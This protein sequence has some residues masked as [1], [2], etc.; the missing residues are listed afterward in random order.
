MSIPHICF[1]GDKILPGCVEGGEASAPQGCHRSAPVNCGTSGMGSVPRC[2]YTCVT[3]PGSS[4]GSLMVSG[5][6]SS[7]TPITGI[8][9]SS[10]NFHHLST[11]THLS[12]ARVSSQSHSPG[13]WEVSEQEGADSA[14]AHRAPDIHPGCVVLWSFCFPLGG[15]Q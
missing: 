3:D 4:D 10:T 13:K 1:M 11:Q 15:A 2:H 7:A 8:F 5:D 9:T 6:A 14:G 12:G